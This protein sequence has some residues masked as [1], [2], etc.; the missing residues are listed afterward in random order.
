MTP[1]TPLFATLAKNSGDGGYLWRKE[2]VDENSDPA[3]KR[4]YPAGPE[5]LREGS[6]GDEQR[7]EGVSLGRYSLLT[8]H[9]NIRSPNSSTTMDG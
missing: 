3:G 6:G 9:Y 7:D 4:F 2:A 5:Q 8:I 1:I